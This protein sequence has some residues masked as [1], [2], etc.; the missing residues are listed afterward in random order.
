MF[1]IKN[2]PTINAIGSARNSCPIPRLYKRF[3]TRLEFAHQEAARGGVRTEKGFNGA[4][5]EKN[6]T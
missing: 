5:G 1:T 3:T 2:L 4:T 6:K